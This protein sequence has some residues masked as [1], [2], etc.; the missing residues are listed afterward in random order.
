MSKSRDQAANPWIAKSHFDVVLQRA[1]E[2][3]ACLRAVLDF[4]NP[5]LLVDNA[6]DWKAAAEELMR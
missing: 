1:Q 6:N 3:E 5:A 4:V 2:T